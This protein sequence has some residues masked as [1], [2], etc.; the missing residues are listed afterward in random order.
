MFLAVC[1]QAI[2]RFSGEFSGIRQLLQFRPTCDNS[3]LPWRLD[4]G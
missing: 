3:F 1:V 2:E 4:K